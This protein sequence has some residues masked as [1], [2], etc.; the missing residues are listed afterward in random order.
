MSKTVCLNIRL[1]LSIPDEMNSQEILQVVPQRVFNP[2]VF[3]RPD[4]TGARSCHNQTRTIQANAGQH[5][6][7]VD[8]PG[9]KANRLL[10]RNILKTITYHCM[11]AGKQTQQPFLLWV[12]SKLGMFKQRKLPCTRQCWGVPL[13]DSHQWDFHTL[14]ICEQD[15]YL[16][17][18]HHLS[19]KITISWP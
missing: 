5:V 19:C 14:Q 13:Y 3:Q 2:E 12:T 17:I 10:M 6:K 4:N 8:I 16:D 9:Q 1:T 15:M 7:R 18:L 11:T